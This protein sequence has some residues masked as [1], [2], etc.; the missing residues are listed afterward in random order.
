MCVLLTIIAKL[1]NVDLILD[2][3]SI[4]ELSSIKSYFF[5][6]MSS[7]TF[8]ELSS[9][10]EMQS[11][12][13][14]ACS[15]LSIINSSHLVRRDEMLS[16][17]TI[18]RWIVPWIDANFRSCNPSRIVVCFECLFCVFVCFAGRHEVHHQRESE[19]KRQICCP[20]SC[21]S[22]AAVRELTRH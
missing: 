15:K 7:S 21:F 3:Q 17:P 16:S 2:R 5:Q 6:E 1:A 9:H 22:P 19:E 12:L 8:I 11:K 13:I 18:M 10:P 20:L 4:M 14:I